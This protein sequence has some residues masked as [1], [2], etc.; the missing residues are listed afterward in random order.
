MNKVVAFLKKE[1]VLSIAWLL[2]LLSML[3]V[4]VDV[5]YIEYIDFHT[6]GILFCLMA[7]MAGLTEQGFFA[8][9]AEKVLR[10]AGDGVGLELMLVLLCFF[11]GMLI[12]NDVALITFVPFAIQILRSSGKEH[13]MIPVIVMQTVA[14]NLGS[15]AT[16]IGNPQNLYI[17]T[18]SGVSLAEFFV[19]MGPY[20]LLAL[21][22]IVLAVL[23]WYRF[24]KNARQTSGGGRDLTGSENEELRSGCTLMGASGRKKEVVYLALF[25]FCLLVV[26]RVVP[27]WLAF[28]LTVLLVFCMDKKVLL[29]VDYSLL[30]TFIGFFVFVGNMGRI[31]PFRELLMNM[32][33]GNEF[34]TSVVLSQVVSNVPAAILLSGFTECYRELLLGVNVGGL[35]TLIASMA[36]LISYKY[37][38]GEASCG[39]G[40]YL[41]VFTAVNAAFL[42]VFLV[43]YS[44]FR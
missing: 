43:V 26:I 11:L 32:L 28:L 27:A 35:G 8:H 42:A 30:L 6:L 4:P 36:S 10:I 24:G 41:L 40:R 5:T 34:I 38:A 20:T 17:F 22:L 13:R 15:M 18:K 29:R 37:A 33:E 2:A 16:P 25:V 7:V 9:L 14:A 12:T 44:V 3:V 21:V 39:K 1:A 23:A 31:A 19:I